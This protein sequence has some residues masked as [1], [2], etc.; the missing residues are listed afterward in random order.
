MVVA[1]YNVLVIVD[2]NGQVATTHIPFFA[3]RDAETAIVQLTT[4]KADSRWPTVIVKRAYV[5][6]TEQVPGG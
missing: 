3:E 1:R 6:S 5:P 2:Y 4:K